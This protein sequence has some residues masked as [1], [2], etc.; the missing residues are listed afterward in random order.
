MGNFFTGLLLKSCS[1]TIAP[2]SAQNLLSAVCPAVSREVRGID[3]CFPGIIYLEF[4]KKSRYVDIGKYLE[5]FGHLENLENLSRNVKYI[6][7]FCPLVSR[8]SGVLEVFWR[9]SAFVK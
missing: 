7:T 6:L 2:A 3:Q 1:V 4:P 9:V 5:F 8:F